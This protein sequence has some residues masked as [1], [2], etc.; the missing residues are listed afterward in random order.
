MSKKPKP[1]GPA[2]FNNPFAQLKNKPAVAKPAAPAP[3]RSVASEPKPKK[4]LLS[5][6]EQERAL[7]L[8]AV[9]EVEP[10]PDR[11]E[12]LLAGAESAARAH[13]EGEALIELAEL[14]AD[15]GAWEHGGEGQH[16]LGH[17]KGLDP[18]VVR[19]L[20]AGEYKV[21]AELDLHG[22]NRLEAQKSFE[23][24]MIKARRDGMR[25]LLIVTGKGLH[26]PEGEAVL[27]ASL[28]GW[29]K[30]PRWSRHLLAYAAAIPRHGG[31]GAV[32]LLLRK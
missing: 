26:N 14:V 20:K 18:R 30:G 16:L 2:P 12:P 25:C 21:D 19:K 9:G 17:V 31:S 15:S 13:D 22:K 24:L 28:V 4:V 5:L 29:L 23:A 7:F 11:P 6:E 27:K 8:E 10:V 3:A 1:S 32:Y